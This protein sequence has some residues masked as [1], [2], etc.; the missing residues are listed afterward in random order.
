MNYNVKLLF[1]FTFVSTVRTYTRVFDY[2]P[3]M[4]TTCCPFHS[5]TPFSF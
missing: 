5:L 1:I 4:K 3:F 2:F